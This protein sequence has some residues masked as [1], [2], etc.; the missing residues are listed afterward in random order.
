[1]FMAAAA[2][3][4][5]AA[6]EKKIENDRPEG[7]LLVS[8]PLE[9]S[10]FETFTD[11]EMRFDLIAESDGTYT[12]AMNQV[13]FVEVMPVRVDIT[14]DGIVL[15]NGRY[16]VSSVIPKYNGSPYEQYEM[17]NLVV[18]AENKVLR[19]SFDCFTMHVEYTG[20]IQIN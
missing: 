5:A 2:M 3:L 7:Y 17:Y 11:T 9:G 8:T 1:M 16:A 6:C 14:V 4:F 18:V 19:V 12:L 20:A 13:K 10:R 15:D